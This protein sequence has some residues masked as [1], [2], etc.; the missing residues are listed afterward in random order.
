MTALPHIDPGYRQ[1]PKLIQ[2]GAR[3]EAVGAVLKWYDVAP[4]DQPVPTAIGEMARAHLVGEAAAGRSELEGDLGFV[5][6]HRCGAEFYFLMVCSW[7]GSNELWETVYAK[8]DD[9]AGGFDVWP[10]ATR[11]VPTF[12]VWELGAVWHEQQAWVRFLS[13]AR[14]DAAVAAYLADQYAGPVG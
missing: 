12:C 2:P 5:V 6:L 4:A 11:H 9:A 1:H 8:P 7:R 13:S 14:D 10:R 3:L